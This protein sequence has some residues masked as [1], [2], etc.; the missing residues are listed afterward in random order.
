MIDGEELCVLSFSVMRSN[1]RK[2][3][4]SKVLGFANEIA[5]ENRAGEKKD[6][7]APYRPGSCCWVVWILIAPPQ[8]HDN[9]NHVKSP[10]IRPKTGDA[11]A[12]ALV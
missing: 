9:T 4:Q 7:I 2:I 12:A 1:L 5:T 3:L 8:C 11:I 6:T 10:L